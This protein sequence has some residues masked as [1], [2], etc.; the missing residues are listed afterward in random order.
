MTTRRQD[1]I[2]LQWLGVF[3]AGFFSFITLVLWSL[4]PSLGQYSRVIVFVNN[5]SIVVYVAI[6]AMGI[7][8][9]QLYH[10]EYRALGTTLVPTKWRYVIYT[11][12]TVALAVLAFGCYVIA[13]PSETLNREKGFAFIFFGLGLLLPS[14][15]MKNDSRFGYKPY[16]D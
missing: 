14:L 13:S 11:I 3:I 1:L 8:M 15:L 2:I 4:N 9:I 10:K 6:A 12:L 16:N 7:Y 5:C